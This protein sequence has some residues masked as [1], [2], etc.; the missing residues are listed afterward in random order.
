MSC[1]SCGA[2][3][4]L[5]RRIC[6]AFTVA[7]VSSVLASYLASCPHSLYSYGLFTFTFPVLFISFACL[8]PFGFGLPLCP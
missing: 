1:L 4:F 6:P 8:D 2:S 5:S 3:H 7:L